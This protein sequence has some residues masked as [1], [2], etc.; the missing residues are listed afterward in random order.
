MK[1]KGFW[2]LLSVLC[3]VGGVWLAASY[4]HTLRW[5]E[6]NSLFLAN[7]AYVQTV[8]SHPAGITQIATNFLYQFYVVPAGGAL[9]FWLFVAADAGLLALLLRHQSGVRAEWPALLLLP[10][11]TICWLPD[12]GFALQT[13]FFLLLLL[14]TVSPSRPWLAAC[15]TVATVC[16]GYVLLPLLPL[17]LLI[18][19]VALS[20]WLGRRR[21]LVWAGCVVAVV[22]SALLP[23]AWSHAVAFVPLAQRPV[24]TL[25]GAWP[26]PLWAG[27]ALTAAVL[28]VGRYA[29]RLKSLLLA[30]VGVVALGAAMGFVS[31]NKNLKIDEHYYRLSDLAD[32]NRWSDLKDDIDFEQIRTNPMECAYAMLAEAAMGTLWDHLFT[33]PINS[34]EAFLFRHESAPFYLNFNRQFYATLGVPDEALHMAFEQGVQTDNGLCL[35]SLRQM[36]DYALDGGDLPLARKYMHLL[37]YTTLHGAWLKARQSRLE[38]LCHQGVRPYPDRTDTFV[39]GYP[40]NSEMVRLCQADSGNLQPYNYLLAGLLLDKEL[41]KF[42]LML[43]YMPLYQSTPL[44]LSF[45]QAAAMLVTQQPE[46]RSACTYAPEVDEQ[47]ANFYRD[48]Q[49]KADMNRY[50]GTFWYYFFFIEKAAALQGSE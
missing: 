44:P 33:Y 21:R 15:A 24:Q 39:G 41:D 48:M 16:V 45:A 8:L 3:V 20:E 25:S 30:G 28:I 17:F 18:V 32:E 50:Q 40:F 10:I 19:L 47:F 23:Q 7:K 6:G 31:A 1:N 29:E 37:G 5:I 38:A 11:A 13:F 26:L 42:A 49:A 43:R 14:L 4:A 27:P 12:V 35:K 34:P 46:L 36:T 2:A 22:V 9:C